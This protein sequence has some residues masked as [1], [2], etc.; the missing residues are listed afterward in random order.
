VIPPRPARDDRRNARLD[1][2][3]VARHPRE[4]IEERLATA[5]PR[6]LRLEAA[7]SGHARARPRDLVLRRT[8]AEW[9]RRLDRLFWRAHRRVKD[10]ALFLRCGESFVC[11][12]VVFRRL[13]AEPIVSIS[14]PPID[15]GRPK[16]LRVRRRL[17]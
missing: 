13:A 11:Q 3:M 5:C 6:Y 9:G 7:L 15:A 4:A 8:W 2:L 14:R 1:R 10:L 12:G 16:P 17:A